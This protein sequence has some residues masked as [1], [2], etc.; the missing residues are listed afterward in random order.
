MAVKK[1]IRYGLG[2]NDWINFEEE[3]ACG[4]QLGMWCRAVGFIKCG[5]VVD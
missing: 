3:G 2:G 1:L 4:G 5:E